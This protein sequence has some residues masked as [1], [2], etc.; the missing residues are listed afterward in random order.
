MLVRKVAAGAA[1]RWFWLLVASELAVMG[2]ASGVAAA[3]ARTAKPVPEVTP[4]PTQLTPA[5][6]LT[7]KPL[8]PE[9]TPE[10]WITAWDLEDRKSTRLNSSHSCASR[11]PSS[12]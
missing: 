7:E 4:V 10:R 11:M 12:A 1:A 5:E 8:P 9:L 2:I 6:I 3:L